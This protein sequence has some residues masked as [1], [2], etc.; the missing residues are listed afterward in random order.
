MHS[1]GS[2]SAGSDRFGLRATPK[3]DLALPAAPPP[4]PGSVQIVNTDMDFFSNLLGGSSD[5]KDSPDVKRQKMSNAL[6]DM[7][8]KQSEFAIRGMADLRLKEAEEEDRKWEARMRDLS[9]QFGQV[10]DTKIQES[11]KRTQE[12][13]AWPRRSKSSRIRSAL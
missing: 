1:S 12:K 4:V 6:E 9:K 10:T 8:R 5:D 3:R 2:A 13:I 11:E 7:M